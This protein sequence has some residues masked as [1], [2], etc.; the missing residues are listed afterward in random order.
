MEEK[1]RLRGFQ[2]GKDLAT[3]MLAGLSWKK[4]LRL[5]DG[6]VMDDVKKSEIGTEVGRQETDAEE[7]HVSVCPLRISVNGGR[8]V[9]KM[10]TG[11][12]RVRSYLVD[13]DGFVFLGFETNEQ[14]QF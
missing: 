8:H 4:I 10:M 2:F 14:G 11:G 7:F 9:L 1:D 12:G 13:G 5:R 6:T 3:S